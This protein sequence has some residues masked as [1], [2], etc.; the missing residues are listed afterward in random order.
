LIVVL[1]SI[2]SPIVEV[3][4]TTAPQPQ[5]LWPTMVL[6]EKGYIE[7]DLKWFPQDDSYHERLKMGIGGAMSR[8]FRSAVRVARQRVWLL[9]EYLLDDDPSCDQLGSLFYETGASDLRVVTAS[10]PNVVERANWLKS[11]EQ[12]LQSRS[13]GTPPQI[14]IYVN[15]KKSVR[16][17]PKVHDRF[18]IVDDVLWHCGATIGGLHDQINALTFGW[19]AQGTKA[20]EFFDRICNLLDENDG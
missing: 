7:G 9:D 17:L 1:G 15:L 11:L 6:G 14:R 13:P 20:V 5:I 2:I 12:D 3:E 18:A 8:A 16:G 10:K 19:S 4:P